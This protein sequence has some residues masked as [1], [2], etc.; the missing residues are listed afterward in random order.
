MGSGPSSKKGR[1][2]AT[3]CQCE[4][5]LKSGQRCRGRAVRGGKLCSIHDPRL[6][7]KF[8]EGRKRGGHI[9]RAK[10]LREEIKEIKSFED[11]LAFLNK[12]IRDTYTGAVTSKQ[13]QAVCTALSG[14][15][16]TIQDMMVEPQGMC[17]G[18]KLYDFDDRR[19]PDPD[20]PDVKAILAD[21]AGREAVRVLSD[22]QQGKR[23]RPLLLDAQKGQESSE[24]DSVEAQNDT[25]GEKVGCGPFTEGDRVF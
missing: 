2:R 16:A 25:E 9:P 1:S 24:N 5:V 19:Y 7:K 6:Q 23:P 11:L 17:G 12:L 20:N 13:A 22:L 3:S 4:H 18:L 15:R 21:P 14:I 10:I 8:A